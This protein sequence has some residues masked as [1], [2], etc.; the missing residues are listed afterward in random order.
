MSEAKVVDNTKTYIYIGVGVVVFA[1]V[2]YFVIA[3]HNKAIS[4]IEDLRQKLADL[5]EKSEKIF[6]KVLQPASTQPQNNNQPMNA[7]FNNNQ[8]PPNF[9]HQQ[10]KVFQNVPQNTKGRNEQNRVFS[11]RNANPNVIHTQNENVNTAP[12]PKK[13]VLFNT[14]VEEIN[15]EE[16]EDSE[17]DL[18]A[19]LEE[20]LKDL[21]VVESEDNTSLK[22][23]D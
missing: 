16:D 10:Q 14:H 19:E 5:E 7:M 6:G 23:D 12:M 3:K 17:E 21:E 15:E 20:E 9:F 2:L 18:D 11:P 4:E 1:G 8:P 22:N 13:H